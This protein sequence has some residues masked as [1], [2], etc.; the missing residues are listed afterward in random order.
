MKSLFL[1]GAVLASLAAGAAS[2][3]IART[4]SAAPDSA[5][6]APP[7][8]S[9]MAPPES[10]PAKRGVV[11]V[12]SPP[13][14]TLAG[15]LRRGNYVL[16][17]RHASTDWAQRDADIVNYADRS[18]QRNL[19]PIGRAQADS[20][21]KAVAALGLKIGKVLA[22]PMYRCRDTAELAFGRADTT[23][24]LFIKSRASRDVR[25]KWLSTPLTDGALFVLVTHQDP[26]LPLF[27]FQRDQLKEADALLIEPLGHDQ[28][29]LVAQLAPADW[30]RLA[31]RYGK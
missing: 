7:S 15:M 30:T 17:V 13:D 3:P 5:N 24:D 22:S 27:R 6:A 10:A 12:V 19:S 29:K 26:Y 8:R 28:W 11:E 2:P 16:L 1:A 18:A 21:G 23:Q 9:S 20:I 31:A 25:V 4:A 14:S